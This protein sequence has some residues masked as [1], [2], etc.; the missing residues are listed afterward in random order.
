MILL[1]VLFVAAACGTK[2]P[3]YQAI[4]SKSPTAA[5]NTGTA[6]PVPISKYLEDQ[7]VNGEPMTPRTLTDLNVSMPRPPGWTIV[8]DPNQQT[9]YQVLRK[10]DVASYPPTAT[11]MVFKLTGK[12]DPA[13]AIKHGYADAQLS[14]GFHQLSASMNNFKGFPSAMIE[15]SYNVGDQRLHTYNRI[16]IATGAPPANQNYLVQFSVTTAANE[17]QP[18]SNDIEQIIGGFTVASK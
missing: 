17:A 4:W 3:D 10:T 11:L 9:T 2:P 6:K 18:Q 13:E 7:G 8:D 14:D 12:F 16:V 1:A 5:P 15:G